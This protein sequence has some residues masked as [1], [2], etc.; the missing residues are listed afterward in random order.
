MQNKF[1]QDAL[2]YGALLG[3]IMGL[4]RIFETY[5]LF[6]SDREGVGGLFVVEWLASVVIF[7]WLLHRFTKRRALLA[8]DDEG[9]SYGS[10]LG[11]ALAVSML[12]GVVVG[13]MYHIFISIVG[14]DA[15]VEGY[16][17][18]INE[19]YALI[20]DSGVQLPSDYMEMFEDIKDVLRRSEAPSMFDNLLASL[21]TYMFTG[22]VVG[23]I[24][25][26]IVRRKPQYPQPNNTLNQQ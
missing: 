21:Q 22:L 17:S 6:L 24:I 3:L 23:L 1:W 14:Y 26:A 12:A 16:I 5:D 7:I 13:V 8:P 9:F 11:Y 18:L 4:S 2:K 15:Y 19:Y 10:G 25:A 20:A